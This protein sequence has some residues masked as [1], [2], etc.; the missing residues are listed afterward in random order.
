MKNKFLVFV[1]FL[2]ALSISSLVIVESIFAQADSSRGK[3]SAS[4]YGHMMTEAFDFIKRNYVEP[5][6]DEAVFEG[7]LKGMFQALG[8]PYSQ[9]LTRKD[10]EE[11]SKT[12]EGNY[13]GIGVTIT[14]KDASKGG[15]NLD[16]GLSYVKILTPFEEGP[17]YRAGIRSGDYITAVDDKSASLMT[18]EQ[19]VELLR[20]QEGTKVKVSILRGKD[21]KL[22]FELV[23]EKLDIQTVKSDII[24]KDV[25]YIRIV[26]FNPNTGN[27]F[28]KA[29]EKLKSHD[30]KSLILDLRL[31][32]GGFLKD[33][34]KIAD[35]ILVEG[36]IVSTKAR[37]A[38]TPFE[39]KAS[40]EYLVPLDMKI[41]ALI[42]KHSAS[43]S[44]VLVGALKDHQRAYVVGEKSYGKGVIQ[45]VIPFHTG[46]FKIT[47]SKYYTPS[48]QSIHNIG[49][50]PDLEI[51]SK[52]FS[53]EEVA[54]YKE[55]FDKDLI[56]HFLKDRK[57]ITEAEI[58]DFIDNLVKQHE[59]YNVDKDFLGQYVLNKFYQDTNREALVYN[60]HYDK[61]LRASYEYLIKE[62]NN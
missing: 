10:L 39:Y 47:N 24:G 55:I 62:T 27:Y 52:D 33:A 32:T 51:V 3:L 53:G 9:Y 41:V 42:D 48:G 6:D 22:E 58:D 25:G 16:P 5:V 59:N 57:A 28:R 54:L 12:T 4:N 43:A 26:S 31:N 19:V 13:V 49:I 45:N 18:V 17:A 8:D 44:E 56:G 11:I 14:K 20:G 37:D 46:G 15:D 30:I 50:K 34:I 23:R 29:L 36:T 7:A 40:P 2:L 60:L 61:V 38:K 35:D 21:L 1:Y